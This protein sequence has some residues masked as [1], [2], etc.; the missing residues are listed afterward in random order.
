M[1]P[2]PASPSDA[3]GPGQPSGRTRAVLG[4]TFLLTAAGGGSAWAL[5]N[6]LIN[7]P[8]R[9]MTADMEYYDQERFA[10]VRPLLPAAGTIGYRE[11]DPPRSEV[12]PVVRFTQ[13]VVA[14]VVLRENGDEAIV[15]VN[16]RP[17]GRP[18]F[19]ASWGR[20]PLFD[21]GNGVRLFGSGPP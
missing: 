3:G 12:G 1:K 4:L 15:L 13:Y 5:G 2:T 9:E 19:E 21:A 7:L 6:A 20:T 8:D 18:A 14:P 17:E 11:D 10:T 16:G